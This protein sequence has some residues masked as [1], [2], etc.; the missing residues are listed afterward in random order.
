VARLL[1]EAL[2]RMVAHG[3]LVPELELVI[4]KQSPSRTV[5]RR[6][7]RTAFKRC[8]G[9]SGVFGARSTP[10]AFSMISMAGYRTLDSSTSSYAPD[11]RTAASRGYRTTS[12]SP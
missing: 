8:S 6:T 1:S 12:Q 10:R 11:V 9:A 3:N 5:R 7:R 2:V 4:G